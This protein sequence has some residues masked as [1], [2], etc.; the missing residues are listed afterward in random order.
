VRRKFERIFGCTQVR[1]MR[2]ESGEIDG[3]GGDA[4]RAPR[5]RSRAKQGDPMERENGDICCTA[6]I[7]IVRLLLEIQ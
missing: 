4:V 5:P 1:G 3:D 6:N 2:E 7:A